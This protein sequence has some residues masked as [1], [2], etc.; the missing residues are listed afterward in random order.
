MDNLPTAC[1]CMACKEKS[2]FYM[3]ND[4]EKIWKKNKI[5]D[6]WKI[7]WNSIK[8]YKNTLS[9]DSPVVV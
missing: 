4:W 6:A 7:I 2:S 1:F 3:L 5:C 9:G 8:G